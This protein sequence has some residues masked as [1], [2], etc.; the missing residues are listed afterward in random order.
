MSRFVI[1]GAGAVGS[2]L[3]AALTEQE[4]SDRRQ[5]L[6]IARGPALEHL[7]ENPLLLRTVTGDRRIPLRVAS[8]E[9]ATLRVGDVLVLAVKA[10]HVAQ[11]ASDLAWRPVF[12]GDAVVG[13]AAEV[14]PIVTTQNGIDAEET[15]ARWFAHVVA[16]TVLIAARYTEVGEVRV[17][18]RP[19]LGSALIGE[20]YAPTRVTRNAVDTVAAAWVAAG[21]AVRR[22]GEIGAVKATKLLHSVKNGLE[23]LAGDDEAKRQVGEALEAEARTV[24]EAAGRPIADRGV[25]VI[26]PD[27][28]GGD[29]D[30]G[31]GQGTQSTWQSFARGA[32]SHE[33]DH[34]NGEIARLARLHRV[35]APVNTTL[36]ALLGAAGQRGGGIDLPGLDRLTALLPAGVA[37]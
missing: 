18:G 8:I 26:D 17:G 27:Q 36:Q 14:L 32:D 28:R 19:Y 21:F 13:T 5:T 34:L 3:A 20:P 11:A 30:L 2:A 23:V 16:T 4:Q 35:E 15:V 22:T 9:D 33:I 31:V 1:V 7:R 29:A 25:L 6:L 24:L 12:D 10:Q 37:G